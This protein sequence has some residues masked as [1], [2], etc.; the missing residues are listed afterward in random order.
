M[1]QGIQDEKFINWTTNFI[2]T[3]IS[4]PVTYKRH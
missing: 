2:G 3:N 1:C 4:S